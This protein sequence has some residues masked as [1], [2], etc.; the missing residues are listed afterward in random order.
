MRKNAANS[1]S[2]QCVTAVV[3]VEGRSRNRQASAVAAMRRPHF[4]LH[5]ARAQ[6]I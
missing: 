1:T 4:A 3:H 5:P 2:F 6:S